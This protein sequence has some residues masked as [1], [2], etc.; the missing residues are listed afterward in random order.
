MLCCPDCFN[1]VFLQ[2]HIKANSVKVGKCPFCSGI[3]KPLYESSK[4]L[5]L[6]Q[7]ILDLYEPSP[8]G[9]LFI[10]KLQEDWQIFNADLTKMKKKKLLSFISSDETMS[11][12]KVKSLYPHEDSY[13]R[14]WEEFR[15]ELQHDN[16]FFPRKADRIQIED[17]LDYLVLEKD[18]IPKFIFRARIN[19]EAH[20]YKIEEMGKPPVDKA[21]D[22]R[23]NPKGISYF[24]GASDQITSIAET[25]PYKSE[26]VSVAK[27]QLKKD[28]TLVDLRNPK[29]TISPFGM[30]DDSLLPLYQEHMP[31]LIHL[32]LSLSIPILPYK[33]DLE[34]L[35]TQY[36]CELIKY[37]GFDGIIFK[38]SLGAGDNYVIFQDTSLIGKKVESFRNEEISF[39]S[40]KIKL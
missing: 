22:G 19:R 3:D 16:R 11:T 25:R 8:T 17:L 20:Q 28:V 6:F 27:F 38:S 13:I 30:D 34:Y 36:L 39:T 1:H 9:M 35:P 15:Q 37:K 7:P 23:A 40:V 33:K 12:L 4:L 29:R 21:P 24:Y 31:F 32:G 10:D 5:D 26:I 2:E 14:N 18:K